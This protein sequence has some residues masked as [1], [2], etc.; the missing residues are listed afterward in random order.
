[1]STIIKSI[2]KSIINGIGAFAHC[3]V[4]KRIT[5][6]LHRCGQAFYSAWI[7][8]EF[9]SCGK[10]STFGGFSSLI[11]AHFIHLGNHLYIG[12][13]V[14]WEVRDEY[15]GQHFTPNLSFGNQ[16]SFGDGGHIS[17]VNNI[18]IGNG[19][20]IGRKVFITDN[21]HGASDR[22]LMDTPAHLRPLYSKGPISIEDNVWIGEMVCIM[23][24][25]TIG[26]GSIIGANAV[27]T[28]DIPPYSLVAGNPARIIRQIN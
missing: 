5:N 1:M 23:P 24:G 13:D 21:S 14:I 12:K 18:T 2:L 28:H 22:L 15:R 26:H 20:R 25:V 7:S 27:V 4:S 19:V 17:C 9:G 10:G 11:G 8:H 3:L 6:A 16:S